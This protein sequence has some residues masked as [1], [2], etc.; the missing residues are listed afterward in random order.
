MTTPPANTPPLNTG[1]R[2][3]R[4]WQL[5]F[6]IM[7]RRKVTKAATTFANG[8]AVNLGA[9][10]RA[11][12]TNKFNFQPYIYDNWKHIPRARRPGGKNPLPLRPKDRVRMGR[13]AHSKRCDP[14]TAL[15]V[16]QR[17]TRPG[18][19]R[20]RAM[21]AKKMQRRSATNQKFKPKLLCNTNSALILSEMQIPRCPF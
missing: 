20:S 17:P 12:S 18:R 10:L 7:R 1:T 14:Q 11:G 4:C 3:A 5:H 15:H 8:R 19:N 9:G 2:F 13:P 21:T 6:G 16:C